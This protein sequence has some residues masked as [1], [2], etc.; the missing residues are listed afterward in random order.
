MTYNGHKNWT[1][2]NVALWLFNDEWLYDTVR[3][4][5]RKKT[6]SDAAR[7]ILQELKEYGFSK[8]PDGV[9]YSYAAIRAAIKGDM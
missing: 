7:A 4:Y 2:W 1:H 9:K 6:K 8:T 5:C 3:R